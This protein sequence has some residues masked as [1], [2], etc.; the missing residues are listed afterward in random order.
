LKEF[1]EGTRDEFIRNC[2]DGQYDDVVVIYRSNTSTKF[3]GPFDAELLS[4]LPKSLKYICHNG[5]GY[6]NID[7]PACSEKGAIIYDFPIQNQKS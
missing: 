1:L 7:I 4:V 2:K 6:D 5:A 3:T